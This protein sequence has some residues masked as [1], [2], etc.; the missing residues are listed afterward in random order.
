MIKQPTFLKKKDK[1][2]VCIQGLGFVGIAMMIA[3]ASRLMDKKNIFNVIGVELDNQSGREK[4]K[5]LNSG[6]LPIKTTDKKLKQFFKRSY[7]K[8]NF[9]TSTDNKFIKYADVIISDI[10]LDLTKN[11]NKFLV[12]YSN[13]VLAM[14]TLGKHM[15]ENAL[16][17]VETTL[18]PGTSEKL[19]IPIINKE[20]E[21]RGFTKELM[22]AFSYERVMPGNNY[23]NSIINF[24]RVYSGNTKRASDRCAN[25][26]KKVVN[27]KKFPLTRLNNLSSC[28]TSKILENSYRAVNIAF[29]DEWSRFAENIGID[30]YEVINAI[31]VRPTHSNIMLPG[32][33]VG[34]YCLTKDPLFGLISAE[35]LFKNKYLKFPLSKK[36]VEINNE[37]PQAAVNI[38]EKYLK[39]LNKKKILILGLSYRPDTDDTRYSPSTD[40]AKRLIT[41]G[42]KIYGHDPLVSSWEG[43]EK[44]RIKSLN[45]IPR[46]DAIVLAVAH[47]NYK[48]L[49]TSK[50]T[51]KTKIILDANNILNKTER[52]KMQSNELKYISLGRN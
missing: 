27:T 19:A 47:K 42:A 2:I 6:V 12:N 22:F 39:T 48:T 34:G 14:K 13:F 8:K 28:E 33:G 15:K 17:I 21:K 7:N 30:L 35:Q 38:L 49:K 36:S 37:M 18:P 43:F 23:L 50:F 41:K 4:V 44:C 31:K 52:N 26:Y 10:N 9:F 40:F 24:W 11:K 25:F 51:N 16:V 1:P 45:N 5:Q 3:V 20:R 29:I 46:V 32:L